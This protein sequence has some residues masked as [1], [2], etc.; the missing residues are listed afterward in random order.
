MNMYVYMYTHILH[1][2]M[3]A[4]THTHTFGIIY[5]PYKLGMLLSFTPGMSASK[6]WHSVSD[7]P[8]II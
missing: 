6:I 1:T 5:L 8:K 2:L 3:C 4:N 7:G